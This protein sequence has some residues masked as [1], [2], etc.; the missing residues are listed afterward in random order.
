MVRWDAWVG[1]WACDAWGL[2]MSLWSISVSPCKFNARGRF[3]S[4]LSRPDRERLLTT[5]SIGFGTA[6]LL[7]VKAAL[8][9][10]SEHNGALPANSAE[11]TAFK[12]F[13]KSWQRSIDGVPLD[14]SRT[15]LNTCAASYRM[16]PC[17]HHP[18]LAQ[19]S[20]LRLTALFKPNGNVKRVTLRQLHDR[21]GLLLQEE[22]FVEAVSNAHKMWAPPSIRESTPH[23]PR[24]AG[25]GILQ[26]HRRYVLCC[27]C[28]EVQCAGNSRVSAL[29]AAAADPCIHAVTVALSGGQW[30]MVTGG[31]SF[32]GCS[33]GGAHNTA[34]RCGEARH[35]VVAGLLAAGSGSARLCGRGWP[36]IP[37][38]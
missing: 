20:R 33:I 18:S 3:G 28:P 34:G 16:P 37:P 6:G 14:V 30:W 21:S 5:S 31:V 9:W 36:W 26:C 27:I 15:P 32:R 24:N 11:R 12:E 19:L 1:R 7:L 17:D 10:R 22:N 35:I 8:Q 38:P 13:I 4:L 25:C 23:C 2:D 29:S